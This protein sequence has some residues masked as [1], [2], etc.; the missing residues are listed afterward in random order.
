VIES[1]EWEETLFYSS[2]PLLFLLGPQ[3]FGSLLEVKADKGELPIPSQSETISR[4]TF[5]AE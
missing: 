5:P 1:P 2:L 3:T 4:G